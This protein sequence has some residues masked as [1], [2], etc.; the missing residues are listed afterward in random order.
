MSA[1]GEVGR[2]ERIEDR[3]CDSRLEW[4]RPQLY[5][6]EPGKAELNFD[7]FPDGGPAQAS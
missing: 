1:P 3:Q 5:R 2:S 7:I 4:Q 6:M